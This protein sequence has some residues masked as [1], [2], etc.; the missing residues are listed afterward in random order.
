MAFPLSILLV[1]ILNGDFLVHEVLSVHVGYR[2]VRCFKIRERYKTVPFREVGVIT[3][4]LVLMSIIFNSVP[5]WAY[6]LRR[7]YQTAKTTKSVIQCL[8]RDHRIQIPNE[9][10]SANLYSLLLV[11]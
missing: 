2:F 4:D 11:R 5:L 6:Y 8:F 10:L 7:R 3:S 1:C 9:Q